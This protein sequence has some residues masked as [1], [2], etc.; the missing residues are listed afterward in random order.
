MA[1]K[2]KNEIIFF[3]VNLLV[4]ALGMA[5]IVWFALGLERQDSSANQLLKKS[6]PYAPAIIIGL[7]ALGVVV[8]LPL[9]K[10]K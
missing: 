7:L 10:K 9:F 8:V 6:L 3:G 4:C 5:A 2:N 1:A